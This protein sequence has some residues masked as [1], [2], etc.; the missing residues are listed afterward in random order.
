MN[1]TLTISVLGEFPNDL[2]RLN[3]WGLKFI[4]AGNGSQISKVS[5]AISAATTARVYGVNFTDASGNILSD[6]INLIAGWNILYVKSID[7]VGY[8][9]IKHGK[10]LITDLG[11]SADF[12][13]TPI[14]RT[15]ANIYNN[16]PYSV[17]DFD[18]LPGNTK[19]IYIAYGCTATGNINGLSKLKSLTHFVINNRTTF[20]AGYSGYGISGELTDQISDTLITFTVYGGADTCII[21]VD[22]LPKVVVGTYVYSLIISGENVTVTGKYSSLSRLKGTLNIS[23]ENK[24]SGSVADLPRNITYLSLTNS[25][26]LTGNLSDIPNGLT[27][28]RL[29][30]M[31]VTGSPH[32]LAASS[33]AYIN[34][35]VT[36]SNYVSGKVYYSPMQAFELVFSTSLNAGST[37]SLLLDLSNIASW[38][39]WK[40]VKF[41][42]SDD[43]TTNAQSYIQTLQSKGVTVSIVKK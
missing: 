1:K 18:T 24:I 31:G 26:N 33:L 2:P 27:Y 34:L 30:A 36:L 9:Y 21:N 37:E 35:G 42:T 41:N 39:S 22:K 23:A 17:L 32:Q 25:P 20:P 14:N 5:I 6:E 15:D 40:S 13:T 12:L 16:A 38:D 43:L 7:D 10:T 28:L 4:K 8:L 3:E 11:S 19:N 29:T